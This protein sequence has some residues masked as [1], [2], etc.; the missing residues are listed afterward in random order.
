[1]LK[2]KLILIIAA[3]I[4]EELEMPRIYRKFAAIYETHSLY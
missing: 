1:M 3:A 2:F 4:G